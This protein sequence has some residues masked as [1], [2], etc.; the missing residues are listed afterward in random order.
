MLYLFDDYMSETPNKYSPIFLKFQESPK[1]LHEMTVDEINEALKEEEYSFNTIQNYRSYIKLYLEW[2]QARGIKC[3]PNIADKIKFN[4][5]KV[6]YLIFSVDD[7][8]KQYDI[9][10]DYAKELYGT[11]FTPNPS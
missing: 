4:V 8:H 6:E 1:N 10:L 5:S 3:D 9:L 11:K 2:L 7:I